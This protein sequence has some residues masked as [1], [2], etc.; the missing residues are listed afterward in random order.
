M[1]G[2]CVCNQQFDAA[3]Q[4]T[5]VQQ[6][7]LLQ[8]QGVVAPKPCKLFMINLIHQVILWQQE[9]KEYYCMYGC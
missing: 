7:Q 5:T 8:A 6:V 9:K 1:S 3:S 4:T 2:Y